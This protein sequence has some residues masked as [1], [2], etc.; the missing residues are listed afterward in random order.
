MPHGGYHGPP[1]DKKKEKKTPDT[2]AYSSAA[3]SGYMGAGY[4]PSDIRKKEL[5]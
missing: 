2:S 3:A 5:R 4:T 1:K